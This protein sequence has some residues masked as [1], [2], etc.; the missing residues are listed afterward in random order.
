MSKR[1]YTL[2]SELGITNK[3]LIEFLWMNG[4]EAKNHLSIINSEV[5][6]LV[7]NKFK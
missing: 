7:V 4:I 6:K 5:E 2:A 1:I 3:R